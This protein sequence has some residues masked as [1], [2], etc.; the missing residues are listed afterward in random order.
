MLRLQLGQLKQRRWLTAA[1][2]IRN[3]CANK[4]RFKLMSGWFQWRGYSTAKQEAGLKTANELLKRREVELLKAQSV[5][6]Q[7]SDEAEVC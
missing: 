1:Q 3:Y 5:L 6:D 7:K 2:I 4:E